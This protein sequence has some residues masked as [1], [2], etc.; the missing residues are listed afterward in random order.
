MA[1]WAAAIQ[2]ALSLYGQHSAQN[3]LDQTGRRIRGMGESN[4]AS[5]LGPGGFGGFETDRWGGQQFQFG[6]DPWMAQF[7][8]MMGQQ[9][10]NMLGG[11]LFQN[12]MFQDAFNSNDM[13]DAFAQA[14]GG[15]QV[16]MPGNFAGD[17][18]GNI[19][20]LFGRGFSNLDRAG[21]TSG[22]VQQNLDASR[23]LAQPFEEQSRNNFFNTE[24]GKTMGATSGSGNRMGM[25]GDAMLRADQ[26]RVLGAQQLGQQQQQ[27]LGNLGM[28]QIGQGFQ[29]EQQGFSQLLQALQQ[30]QSAGQQRLSNAMGLFGMGR[31]TQQ[32]Q[33]G[34]GLQAQSGM[35]NQN[36]FWQNMMLGLLNADANRIGARSG[37]AAAMAQLGSNSSAGQ[38]GFFGGMGDMFGGMNFGGGGGSGGSMFGGGSSGG[39]TGMFSDRRLKTNIK[40]VGDVGGYNWYDFDYIWGQPGVGVMS[41]EIP[42]KFVHKHV[43]GYDIVDYGKLLGAIS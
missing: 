41:D 32:S 12:P 26:G 25:F 33:F 30:N 28:S 14:Q 40:L 35:L 42:Q 31:D 22:L 20:N 15:N 43:S 37:F 23:A 5:F 19:N 38:G 24:F 36:Q 8:Q 3:Q 39:A 9:G 21:D 11:G 27:F 4:P 18:R 7:R 6:E 29:G 1:G 34:M 16:L 17:F 10:G 2:A 13:Q